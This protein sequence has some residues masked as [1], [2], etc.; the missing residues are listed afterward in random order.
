M[1]QE[2][3]VEVDHLKPLNERTPVELCMEL[4]RLAR[5]PPILADPAKILAKAQEVTDL[6]F[7]P[8]TAGG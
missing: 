2:G 4:K 7:R 1:T 5:M 3:F 8:E 6:L